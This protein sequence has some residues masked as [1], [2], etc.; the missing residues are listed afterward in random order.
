MQNY[1]R[2]RLR[3]TRGISFAAALISMARNN[4]PDLDNWLFADEEEELLLVADTALMVSGEVLLE[5]YLNY[6]D[7]YPEYELIHPSEYSGPSEDDE[8]QEWGRLVEDFASLARDMRDG[9]LGEL[10]ADARRAAGT[11]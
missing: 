11:L 1:I 2:D 10:I 7:V 6:R 9:F 4:D 8:E 5:R 3:Q